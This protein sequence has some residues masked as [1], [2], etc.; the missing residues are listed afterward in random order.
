MGIDGVV[1]TKKHICEFQ[2]WF[3]YNQKLFVHHG[4]H[5]IV[6]WSDKQQ[7]GKIHQTYRG[8]YPTIRCGLLDKRLRLDQS[9]NYRMVNWYHISGLSSSQMYLFHWNKC[10]DTMSQGRGYDCYNDM[11][12]NYRI[13][14]AGIWLTCPTLNCSTTDC[15]LCKRWKTMH[16]FP[17]NTPTRAATMSTWTMIMAAQIKRRTTPQLDVNWWQNNNDLLLLLLSP[18]PSPLSNGLVCE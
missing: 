13:S 1:V 14:S 15:R 3:C 17:T 10:E 11:Q 6:W 5:D 2:G 7:H 8:D 12:Q 18:S 4:Y 16:H 9:S